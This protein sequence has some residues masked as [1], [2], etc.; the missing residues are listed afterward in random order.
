MISKN[1]IGGK[2]AIN[3]ENVHLFYKSFTTVPSTR[4]KIG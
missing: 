2:I 1:D 4:S 3:L